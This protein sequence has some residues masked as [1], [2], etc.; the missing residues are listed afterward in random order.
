MLVETGW[1]QSNNQPAVSCGTKLDIWFAE[2]KLNCSCYLFMYLMF[3][4]YAW[5][6]TLCKNVCSMGNCNCKA[7][8][9]FLF[10]VFE[11]NPYF[12]TLT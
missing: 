8:L 6:V 10:D 2:V 3:L 12:L 7:F 5:Y 11:C 4:S 1:E 9:R